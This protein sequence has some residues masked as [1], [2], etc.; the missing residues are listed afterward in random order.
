MSLQVPHSP[1]RS[2]VLPS[3]AILLIRCQC[4][5][6]LSYTS[7]FFYLEGCAAPYVNVESIVEIEPK[8]SVPV[9]CTFQNF[10]CLQLNDFRTS[11]VALYLYMCPQAWMARIV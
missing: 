6:R 5:E 9:H 11:P 2:L 1:Y 3:R 4:S 8:V 7:F 10:F